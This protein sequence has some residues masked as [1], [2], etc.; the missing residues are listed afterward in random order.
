MRVEALDILDGPFILPSQT[1]DEALRVFEAVPFS[2]LPVAGEDRCYLGVLHIR[3][4]ALR[5]KN[6]KN[7]ENVVKFIS[8]LRPLKAG[9]IV[10]R[11]E[12]AGHHDIVPFV[13]AENRLKGFV[14]KDQI[15][16]KTSRYYRQLAEQ[17]RKLLEASY[18][19]II[20]INADGNIIV[21]NPAAER[22][23]KRKR[24]EVIGKHIS[25]LDPN[26]GLTETLER[27]VAA[28]AIRTEINGTVILANRS[29]L[30]YEGKCVGAMSVFLD[31]SEY[32]SICSELQMSRT[33]IKELDAIFESS[34]DGFYIANH[35]G[36]VTRVNS[37]W[38][39]FCGFPRAEVI[40]KTAYDLVG[41]GCYD[42]SAAVAAIEQKKTVT[43]LVNI[44]SGPR[45]GKQVMATGTPIFDDN[46]ELAQVVVN[47]RD[48]TDL[49]EL[50]H[51]LE[52]TEELNRRYASEL[53]QIRLQQLKMDDIVAKS[54]A[55][56]RV[57][58]MAARIATVDS[59]VLIMGESGVGKEV[60]AN[61]IHAL[62]RRNDK[63]FIK[64][65]CGAIPENLLE[66]ELF[67]YAGGAFTGAKRE[68]KPGMFELASN[69]TLFLDEIGEL[70][71]GLQ[72]KLL[73]VLQEKTLVRV[74]G[75]KPIPVDVRVI[76]ATNKDLPDMVKH[77]MFRDDLFY[78]LNVFGIQIPPLRQ[79]R[80]DLPALLHDILRKINKKYGAQK[81]MSPGAVERL[82][83]YD[84]PGN[85]REVENV[86]ERLVVL[87]NEPI[88]E[89]H[90]L[91]EGMQMTAPGMHS[92]EKEAVMLNRV[93]PYK[94]AI[95]ELEML[96]LE[97]ALAEQGSTR[98]VAK[99]LDVNQ[100]TIVRKM[101]QYNIVRDDA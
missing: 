33:L 22:I 15:L 34:Y 50:R 6:Q 56:Q 38:E 96:L 23:L 68:G 84:W 59:T 53:E 72:V 25:F 40:G 81:K 67:G 76:A 29:P 41:A 87:V 12:S 36:R 26:M 88:I 44:M 35:E 86:M 64:I 18:N 5:A 7:D 89:I 16:S 52:S 65:N 62:S 4:L 69:G 3:D 45:K 57:V 47:V 93:V 82:F 94:Q 2:T 99:V 46:G 49:E 91:P 101:Q 63:S 70:P 13:D 90:H 75:T 79:R 28:T 78:R 74:G 48:M 73:R 61:K 37:A 51:Q 1:P 17:D 58:E 60:I 42:Q 14:T 10:D 77:G 66:S 31:V 39:K 19:G 21:F 71:L 55:M 24:T 83:N 43:F 100:S 32:E 27:P 11:S 30:M 85:V 92:V 20:A 8:Q 95:E 97:K 98:K 9:D 54:P 80:E